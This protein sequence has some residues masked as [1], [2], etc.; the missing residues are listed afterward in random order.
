MSRWL[1]F[2][3]ASSVELFTRR[4]L[5]IT[6]CLPTSTH[7]KYVLAS[8]TTRKMT[9]GRT[10]VSACECGSS[11]S[12]ENRPKPSPMQA[13]RRI[14][15]LPRHSKESTVSQVLVAVDR[16]SARPV[17]WACARRAI[18]AAVF[19]TLGSCDR[20]LLWPYQSTYSRS[21]ESMSSLT[22][23]KYKR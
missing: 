8:Q 14:I 10:C 3:L 21:K 19:P 16:C 5:R 11:H 9:S 2:R 18:V 6:K 22:V 15:L 7:K 4:F 20:H 1:L 23:R 13:T 17:L 12:Q